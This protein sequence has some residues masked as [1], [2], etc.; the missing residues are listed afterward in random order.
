MSSLIETILFL[1]AKSNEK[2][3]S[4]CEWNHLKTKNRKY[5]EMGVL[6]EENQWENKEIT[7]LYFIF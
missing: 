2:Y 7:V 1:L 3:E 6:K 4:H 5:G